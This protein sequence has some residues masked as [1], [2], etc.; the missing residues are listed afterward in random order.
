[1]RKFRLRSEPAI[2]FV[3]LLQRRLHQLVDDAG[4][5]VCGAAGKAFVVFDRRHNAI[6]R[7]D[8]FVMAIGVSMGHGQQ[9]TAEAWTTI[10]LILWEDRFRR[11]MAC[12]LESESQ[13][14]ASHP[15]R[16][17]PARPL[18]IASPHRVVHRD[19]P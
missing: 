2:V 8:D 13:S 9:H 19:L 1:M 3:E 5:Q 10:S 11:R 18:D 4:M 16:S 7:L 12:P 15:A 14:T 6:G 17:S